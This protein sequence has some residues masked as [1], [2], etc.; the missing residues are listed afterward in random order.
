[1]IDDQSSSQQLKK[2]SEYVESYI[3]DQ[4]SQNLRDKSMK[5]EEDIVSSKS[6]TIN[7]K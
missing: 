6:Q 1:M 4:M 7:H 3:N 2:Q 5:I